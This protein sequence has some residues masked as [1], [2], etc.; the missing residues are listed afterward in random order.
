MVR[1]W[2]LVYCGCLVSPAGLGGSWEFKS[3]LDPPPCPPAHPLGLLL[4]LSQLL[5]AVISYPYGCGFFR[6]LPKLSKKN[7]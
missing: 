4:M 2:M 6:L 1:W 3:Q 7:Y 5:R